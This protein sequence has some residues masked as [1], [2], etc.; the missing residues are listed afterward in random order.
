MGLN[1]TETGFGVGCVI[2]V[3]GVLGYLF[4]IFKGFVDVFTDFL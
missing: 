2:L 1:A 4:N 3:P